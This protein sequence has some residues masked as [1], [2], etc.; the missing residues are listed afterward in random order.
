MLNTIHPMQV[1]TLQRHCKAAMKEH[2]GQGL[3]QALLVASTTQPEN[4]GFT[5]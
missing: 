3:I 1:S 4:P 5:I 2:D